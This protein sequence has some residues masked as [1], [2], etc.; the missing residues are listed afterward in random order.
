MVFG[1]PTSKASKHLYVLL[2]YSCG[3]INK[4]LKIEI[5]SEIQLKEPE[6]PGGYNAT[7]N[8]PP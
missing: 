3:R 2:L 6:M 8:I 4:N 1:F 7:A 5:H